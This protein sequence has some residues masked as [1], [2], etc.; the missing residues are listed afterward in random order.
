MEKILPEMGSM[1]VKAGVK[2]SGII[3]SLLS[4]L[5]SSSLN[6]LLSY[7]SKN[8]VNEFEN[9]VVRNV[10]TCLTSSVSES[11]LVTLLVTGHKTENPKDS[12]LP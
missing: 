5:L 1:V 11:E 3:S 8:W 2:S 6:V 12:R 7:L 10:E 4:S 9:Y